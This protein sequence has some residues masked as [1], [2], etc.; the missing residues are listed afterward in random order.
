MLGGV[1]VDGGRQDAAG[2]LLA[3]LSQILLVPLQP[4]GDRLGQ[5]ALQP[6]QQQRLGLLAAQ[7]ADLVQLL[8]LLL[9]QLLR[10]LGAPLD[11]GLALR[12]LAL[13]VFQGA[14]LLEQG[15]AFLLQAVLALVEAAFLVAQLGADLIHLAVEFLAL[16]VEVVLGL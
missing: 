4:A 12:Q 1:A 6:F 16:L 10:L 11:L 5:L 13:A 8:R 2:L 14:L 7:A 15:L 3:G 9:D